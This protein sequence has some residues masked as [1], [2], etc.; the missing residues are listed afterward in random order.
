MTLSKGNVLAK[1]NEDG[2]VATSELA[3]KFTVE[4]CSYEDNGLVVALLRVVE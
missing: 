1:L 3:R 2:T 4:Q